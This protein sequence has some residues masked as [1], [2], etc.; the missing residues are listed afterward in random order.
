MRLTLSMLTALFLM[1]C[2][3]APP[4][5][6]SLVEQIDA[7]ETVAPA[8]LRRGFLDADDL[9]ARLERLHELE[10]QALAIVEDE[11]L[12]LGSIGS[13]ILDTY[14]ASLTGHYVM[15]RF[16]EHLANSSAAEPH[17]RWVRR[18]RE[19]MEAAGEGSMEEP[20]PVVTPVEGRM[21][22]ISKGWNPV[23]SVYRSDDDVPFSLLLQVQTGSGPFEHLSFD[24]S[25][26]FE[27]MRRDF[28][29]ATAAAE[30]DRQPAPEDDGAAEDA[31]G[32]V[33]E[34]RPPDADFTPFTLIGYLAK[35][36][37]SAAQTAVGTYLA[38]NGR[39]D[40]A[41]EW[42][43]AASDS[44]NL[45]ANSFL[46][47]MHWER[48]RTAADEA[49]REAALEQVM[50]HYRQ[51]ISLGSADAMYALGVLYVN[52]HYEDENRSSGVGLLKQA[53]AAKHSEAAMFLAHLH[54]AGEVV[55]RDLS[56]ARD[57][58]ATAARDG[59]PFAR[60]SYARFLLDR[61]VEQPGDP[62][63][64]EWLEEMAEEGE[65]ESMLLLG[66][67]HARGLGTPESP[68]RAVAWFKQAVDEAP[69]DPNLVNEVA[70]T[71]AVSDRDDLR[72]ERYARR[73]MDRMMEA[74]ERARSQPELLDTWAATYAAT[75]DFKRAVTLQEQALDAAAADD[76]DD[77]RDVLR[78]HLD[79][80][81][82]RRTISEAVP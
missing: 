7:G 48:A 21:Y 22:A 3:T 44:G 64:L 80:F 1:G 76:R 56:T 20:L 78:R 30:R 17:E 16:Y 62:R 8:E 54:Y 77:V 66:N 42:L 82:S 12:K 11:P 29:D 6:H 32:A 36:N 43:G 59:N 37:D 18:I 14:Y 23:G 69:T 35:R 57:Y 4:D 65:A 46:A 72:R 71:L 75:G 68:R 9:P 28:A 40:D 15:A 26:L 73:I 53:A 5:Y 51:A 55:E 47:R 13:A 45:L 24:L 25:S 50:E 10:S 33:A 58:Y 70:W 41:M 81:R 60:K 19:D 2:Q 52:G 67:L 61:D 31:E 38:N 39:F 27:S 79:A 49:T 34:L 63:V 74:S